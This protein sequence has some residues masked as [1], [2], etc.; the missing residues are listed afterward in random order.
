MTCIICNSQLIITNN[1]SYCINKVND[2]HHLY[3]EGVYSKLIRYTSDIINCII[4]VYQNELI[5]REDVCNKHFC[6]FNDDIQKIFYRLIKD[7]S[8]LL[9]KEVYNIYKEEIF[10]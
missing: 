2:L 4:L 3:F 10:K 6:F 1:G 5:L 9:K 8:E 7:N